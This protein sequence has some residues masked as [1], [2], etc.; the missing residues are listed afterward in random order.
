M[1]LSLFFLAHINTLSV[2]VQFQGRLFKILCCFHSD[3][4]V[5]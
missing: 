5:V 3:A 2:S 1:F 4:R